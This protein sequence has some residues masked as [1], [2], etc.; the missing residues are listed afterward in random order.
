MS[1][2]LRPKQLVLASGLFVTIK[3]RQVVIV[4]QDSLEKV[5]RIQKTRTDQ[6]F[7][8]GDNTQSSTDSRNFGWIPVENII[9][10]VFWPRLKQD[11]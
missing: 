5:K 10:K 8:V 6:V 11:P 9:A 2:V 3:P 4:C 1:P 7:I